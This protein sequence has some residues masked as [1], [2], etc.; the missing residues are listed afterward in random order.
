MLIS[1][2]INNLITIF[3]TEL[4]KR[5]YFS[6]QIMS[7]IQVSDRVESS[8]NRLERLKELCEPK[9]LNDVLI[10]ASD[11]QNEHFPIFSNPC[12]TDKAQTVAVAVFDFMKKTM[13][14][15]VDRPIDSE[16]LLKILME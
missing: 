5:M 10:I 9:N 7:E 8:L 1:K 4:I 13:S 14:I 3:E 6:F 12:E 2:L 16:P 15:Y 11:N